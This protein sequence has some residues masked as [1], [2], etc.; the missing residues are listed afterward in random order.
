[1]EILDVSYN[2]SIAG[3]V[4]LDKVMLKAEKNEDGSLLKDFN[5]LNYELMNKNRFSL[6]K[7]LNLSGNS[8]DGFDIMSILL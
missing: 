1:L 7:E 8:L 6:L 4:E 3:S 2:Y 5:Q